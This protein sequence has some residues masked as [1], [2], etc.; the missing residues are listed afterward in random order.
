MGKGKCAEKI[1]NEASK[2]SLTVQGRE[3]EDIQNEFLGITEREVWVFGSFLA[4]KMRLR[5]SRMIKDVQ[6]EARKEV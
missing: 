5:M 2:K 3:N 4:E 1:I 6:M